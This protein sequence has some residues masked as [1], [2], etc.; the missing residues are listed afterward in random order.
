VY[1]FL[2]SGA[3]LGPPSGRPTPPGDPQVPWDVAWSTA[4][5]RALSVWERT[6]PP[7]HA[8]SDVVGVVH[9]LVPPA[10]RRPGGRR[11]Q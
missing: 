7:Y 6:E 10:P 2:P 9:Q 5:G 1:T 8:Q 11:V 4:T 3:V